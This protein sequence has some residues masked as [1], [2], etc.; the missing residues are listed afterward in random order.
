ML[1][2]MKT[3]IYAAPAVKGLISAEILVYKP[4]DQRFLSISQSSNVHAH[5]KQRKAKWSD[6]TARSTL[7]RM[8]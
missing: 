4:R 2:K 8:K 7:V 1:I 3:R 5:L 6:G